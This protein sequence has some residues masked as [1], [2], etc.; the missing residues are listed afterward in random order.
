MRKKKGRTLA[1]LGAFADLPV[2]RN[3][4]LASALFV[5]NYAPGWDLDYTLHFWSLAVEEHFY[6][7]WPFVMAMLPKRALSAAIGLTL[8]VCAW[9]SIETHNL[10]FH[11][12]AG[13]APWSVRTDTR[14]DAILM[15]CVAALAIA[16]RPSWK[17]PAW[18]T[19]PIAAAIV[20]ALIYGCPMRPAVL[21]VLF[22]ALIVST[23]QNPASI[24]GRALEV[25]AVQ[26]VGRLSYSLY[27][28]QG[29]FLHYTDSD[30][31]WLKS[32]HRFP[33]NV[34]LTFAV[35]TA[36]HYL[37]ERP[38]VRLGRWLIAHGKTASIHGGTWN[39]YSKD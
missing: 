22:A 4:L 2:T 8:A 12:F 31:A 29:L 39:V 35:A 24:V 13:E 3:E 15:G 18:T 1:L 30:P 20:L 32:L 19:G 23:V 5:R 37:I 25:P 10:L 17:M 38:A 28:V 11:R 21:S 16:R 33:L 26:W 9:R 27:V 36:V 34:V 6:L 14:L 7:L